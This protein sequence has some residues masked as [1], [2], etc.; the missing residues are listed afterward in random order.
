MKEL[1]NNFVLAFMYLQSEDNNETF[2]VGAVIKN[3]AV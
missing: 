1:A 2:T 3:L